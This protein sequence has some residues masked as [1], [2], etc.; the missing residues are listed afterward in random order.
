M[1]CSIIIEFNNV[2]ADQALTDELIVQTHL[3]RTMQ[4][5]NLDFLVCKTFG[6]ASVTRARVR[7][8]LNAV[9]IGDVAI[10][11]QKSNGY[12]HRVGIL[13]ALVIAGI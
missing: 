5:N 11:L 12:A 1:H 6:V 10:Q 2:G 8:S 4:T 7:K 9:P 3:P 13:S